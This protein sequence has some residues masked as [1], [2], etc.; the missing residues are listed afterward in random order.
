[1]QIGLLPAAVHDAFV[2]AGLVVAGAVFTYEVR[3]RGRSDP[4]LWCLV[5]GALVGGLLVSRLAGWARHLD[6]GRNPNLA[7]QWLYGGRS[8]LSGLFGAYLGVLIA[9]R[10]CR[11]P[12]RSGDLFAPAVAAGM[13]VGRVGCLLTERPGT[14]TGASWGVTLSA[15]DAARFPGTPA[16]VPLHPSFAYEIVFQLV[17]LAVLIALRERVSRPDA[18]F[19]GYLAG[20]AAF[21]FTVEFVRGNE[22][23][24]AGLSRSQIFL[25]CCLPLLG[26]RLRTLAR[27]RHEETAWAR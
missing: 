4:R 15:A 23:V 25:L 10:L 6:P 1:M 26:W 14:P 9:K 27:A 18:L 19:T 11:Y 16:G 5:A 8:I 24:A 3:R 13:A 12:W 21:R 2:G 17:A 20:Y 22:V 7:E